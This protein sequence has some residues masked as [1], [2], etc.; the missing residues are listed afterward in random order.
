MSSD[1]VPILSQRPGTGAPTGRLWSWG[2]A[3]GLVG[4]M[5]R[6]VDGFSVVSV[7]FCLGGRKLR[8]AGR[9]QGPGQPS[10]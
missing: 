1:S 2:L 5:A 10:S 4:G 3:S 8:R 7:P 9:P 6:G